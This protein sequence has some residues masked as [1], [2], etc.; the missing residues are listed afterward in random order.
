MP[1]GAR[2]FAAEIT[3]GCLG[4]LAITSI[5]IYYAIKKFKEKRNHFKPDNNV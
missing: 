1:I 4:V 5:G 2:T 3:G